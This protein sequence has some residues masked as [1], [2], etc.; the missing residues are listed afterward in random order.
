VPTKTWNVSAEQ[1][2]S[3]SPNAGAK[4]GSA[5]GSEQHAPVGL[6]S[7]KVMRHLIKLSLDWTGVFQITSAKL[8]L[9]TSGQT[10]VA[11]GG[12]PRFYVGRCTADFSSGGGGEGNWVTDA[13][14][15]YGGPA[16][17]GGVDSGLITQSEGKWISVDVTAHV[18]AWA[19]ASVLKRDGS[20]GGA[21]AN[22]GLKLYSYD[23]GSTSRTTEFYTRAASSSGW[24]YVEL[25]YS[26]NAPPTVP[27]NLTPANGAVVSTTGGTQVTITGTHNHP[28]GDPIKAVRG[29][30]W[31]ATATDAAIAAGT[32]GSPKNDYQIATTAKNWTLTLGAHTGDPLPGGIDPP[33]AKRTQYRYRVQTQDSKG[34]WSPWSTVDNHAFWTNAKGTTTNVT[35]GVGTDPD[36]SATLSDP[37]YVAGTTK[38]TITAIAV[39]AYEDSQS[40][41]L[42]W[43]SGSQAVGGNPL[44]TTIGYGSGGTVTGPLE[45]YVRYRFVVTLYDDAGVAATSATVYYTPTPTTGPSV[46]SP[47]DRSTKIDSLAWKPTIG[48]AN[49]IDRVGAEV[50]RTAEATGTPAAVLATTT[51]ADTTV[52]A[53]AALGATNLKVASVTGIAIGDQLR[54]GGGN[55]ETVTV[56]AVGTAGAGGTGLTISALANGKAVSD[57][58][59]SLVVARTINLPAWAEALYWRAQKRTSGGTVMEDWSALYPVQVNSLPATP[60]ITFE[61]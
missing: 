45:S 40:A 48:D 4:A 36:I 54:L 7:G 2:L 8:W 28:N 55:P 42:K 12:S 52:A 15:V 25:T 58:V 33:L 6:W 14:T 22:Y 51:L 44:R 32:A 50:Y 39:D 34:A 19:P 20:P 23:E 3:S 43:S 53:I 10:H 16:A 61:A 24:P 27:T 46:M 37:D 35:I 47:I 59:K 13:S 21:G 26:D 56:S 60:A 30:V 18:E 38:G 11:F 57:T 9:K 31:A 1:H 49:P 41:P 29:Q 5:S 17:T